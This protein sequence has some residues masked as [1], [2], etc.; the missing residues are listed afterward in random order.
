MFASTGLT[1]RRHQGTSSAFHRVILTTGWKAHSRWVGQAT[2]T[3]P[4]LLLPSQRDSSH[5]LA[6][7]IIC[8]VISSAFFHS[9]THSEVAPRQ[10]IRAS[11]CLHV[12]RL[13]S[14]SNVQISPEVTSQRLPAPLDSQLTRGTHTQAQHSLSLSISASTNTKPIEWIGQLP[15]TSHAGT[16]TPQTIRFRG[17]RH[18]THAS[19]K[20]TR[21]HW[22]GH[23]LV[24]VCVQF[25]LF[26]PFSLL[27]TFS[28]LCCCCCFCFRSY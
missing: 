8:L 9:S 28:R 25:N 16:P 2:Q 10:H 1:E 13:G 7:L 11:N 5:T 23:R 17:V 27:S 15:N 14:T 24:C 18:T 21:R 26:A 6:K 12:D 19:G 4:S 20:L 22:P 3:Q